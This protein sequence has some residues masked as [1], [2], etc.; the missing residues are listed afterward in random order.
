MRVIKNLKLVYF[1]LL[2]QVFVGCKT[3]QYV[4]VK[5]VEYVHVKDSVYF[6]DTL[7]RVELEKARLSDFV[8]VGDTLVLSTDLARSTAYLDT[9]SGKICGTLENTKKYVEKNVPL[10]EKIVYKDSVITKEVPVP[11]EVEKIVKKPPLVTKILA[12]IGFAAL[13]LLAG[14]LVWKFAKI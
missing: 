10:K 5:E 6:R 11:V 12:W 1:A 8:N 13:M 4:P 14:A 3:I 9:T 7:V 2:L